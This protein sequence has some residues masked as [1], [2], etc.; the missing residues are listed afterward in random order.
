L[1]YAPLGVK[2]VS[3]SPIANARSVTPGLLET[4]GAQLIDGRFFTEHDRAP[5]VMIDSLL[6]GRLWPGRSAV[7]Q[8]FRLG[9]GDP[10]RRVTV[11]GVVRHLNI[12]SLVDDTLPQIF[13]PFALWQR[14][15]MAFVV[16][17]H[18]EPAALV[19]DIRA[20]VSGF[21]P[22]LPIFDVRP[23]AAYV[24]SARSVRQFTMWLA[25]VFAG[26]AFVLTCIGVYGVLA[27]AVT[28]RRHEF[29]V[30]RALGADTARVMRDVLGEGARFAAIGCLGG[31]A[32]A[33][34]AARLLQSQLYA[35]DTRDPLTYGVAVLLIASGAAS[36]CWIPARRA[37]SIS[38]MDALRGE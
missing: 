34:A 20:T 21:D 18:T 22:R 25:V 27:Y 16:Q 3:G 2:D 8:P 33:A 11:I 30:R 13:V 23:L 7:G 38:P 24:A 29:G 17:T 31:V 32:G 15:P 5:V 4:L 28:S 35:V 12:R 1:T 19:P 36:A 9:Q 37:T 14:N 6:A 10:D 26:T